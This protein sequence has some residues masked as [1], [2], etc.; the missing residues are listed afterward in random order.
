MTETLSRYAFA[1][2]LITGERFY[3][4]R[5]QDDSTEM[6]AF[7]DYRLL[8]LSRA[9]GFMASGHE[10]GLLLHSDRTS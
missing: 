2:L 1:A 7:P 9:I 6:I 8:T 10:Q 4:V 3:N 5:R